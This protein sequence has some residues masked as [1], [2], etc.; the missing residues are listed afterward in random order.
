MG[1]AQLQP[2]AIIGAAGAIGYAVAAE[3]RRRH[4]PH[5]VIGRSGSR[6]EAAFGGTAE[7]VPADI[8]DLAAAQHALKG[9]SAAIY[10]VGLPYPEHGRHPALLR[11]V[12]EAA[13]REGVSRLALVSSVYGYGRPQTPLVAE[14]HPRE[15]HTRKG[16]YRKEQEDVAMA[17]H[18]Q[19]GLRTLVLR[20]PDFYG[21]HAE[22]SLADQVFAA[23]V[24][25]ATANWIGPADLPHEFVFTPDVGP[26]VADLLAREDSV[27]EAWNVAGPGTITGREFIRAAYRVRGLAPRFRTI[28]PTLLRV[29]GWVSPLLRELRELYYLQTTPVILD[30]AKLHRLLGTLQKTPYP[31]G[32]RTTMEWYAARPSPAV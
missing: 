16:R 8:S 7:V 9:A 27:G 29:G 4:L 17:A 5:R 10:C 22:L 1:T 26:I 32:I 25:G 13:Q 11:S 2:I 28:G 31:E 30:D 23:A 12:V 19:R 3:F 21:P 24:K 18:G 14:T 6:L 15:P 20:L